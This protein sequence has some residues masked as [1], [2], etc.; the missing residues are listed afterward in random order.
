[1]QQFRHSTTWNSQ[2]TASNQKCK[3]VEKYDT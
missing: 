2:C 3:D 1:M